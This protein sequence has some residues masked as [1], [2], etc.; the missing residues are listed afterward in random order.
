MITDS[1]ISFLS[2]AHF[3]FSGISYQT[4]LYK[5]LALESLSHDLLLG[6]PREDRSAGY[7]QGTDK[8]VVRLGRREKF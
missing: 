1:F 2:L 8:L 6:N 5:Q 4:L 7:V 3:I